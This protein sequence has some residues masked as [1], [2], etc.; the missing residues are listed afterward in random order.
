MI[1]QLLSPSK[2]PASPDLGDAKAV[3]GGEAGRQG[4]F[5]RVLSALGGAEAKGE[6]A[7]TGEGEAAEAAIPGTALP[8]VAESGKNLP[9][10]PETLPETAETPE[11]ADPEQAVTAEAAEA[12][13]ALLALVA[14]QPAQPAT[15]ETAAKGAQAPAAAPQLPAGLPQAAQQLVADAGTQAKG[16]GAKAAAAPAVAIQV[17]PL[18]ASAEAAAPRD[19]AAAGDKSA[20]E[21]SA[22]L[23]V[24]TGSGKPQR[25]LAG[26]DRP[27]PEA[28]T[29][30]TGKVSAEPA[31]IQPAASA[32]PA[33]PVA[34]APAA[35]GAEAASPFT[36]AKPALDTQVAR[37][38][39]RI[40]DSLASAR[41]AMVG[42]GAT[43]ALD[44]AEFG[45]LS[46]RFDQRRDGQMTVQ[47]AA[48]DPDAHRAVAAAIADR[49]HFGQPDGGQSN[50]QQNAQ[51]GASNA[52]TRGGAMAERD[53]G[54]AEGNAAQRERNDGRG[55]T[56]GN[57]SGK[58]AGGEGRSG[59]YA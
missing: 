32:Q 35:A 13:A 38:I 36:A 58:S 40:V 22:K 25:D 52:S 42:K 5:S 51:G 33:M 15:T 37:E 39:G 16:E 9:V 47:L 34:A 45:E 1:S 31:T 49:P 21:I 24:D 6:A 30:P 57:D 29:R 46:L 23:P 2:I 44:H 14:P 20:T 19:T 50:A 56:A 17:A 3:K 8:G 7:A 28:T 18:P 10:D 4:A 11:D 53:N 48:A 41:E 12:A 26:G 54:S 43:L 27:A 55:S 59:I